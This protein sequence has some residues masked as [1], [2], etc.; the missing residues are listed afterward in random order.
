MTL[1]TFVM[2]KKRKLKEKATAEKKESKKKKDKL[3][4]GKKIELLAF[5]EQDPVNILLIFSRHNLRH[6]WQGAL[7]TR[8]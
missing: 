6:F 2:W 5:L 3:Q 8:S 1:Q 4:S 7:P